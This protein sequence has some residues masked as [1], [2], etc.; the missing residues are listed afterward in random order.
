MSKKQKSI[1]IYK[2]IKKKKMKKYFYFYLKELL[3]VNKQINKIIE[4]RNAN[5]YFMKY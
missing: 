2:K 3:L 5:I 4:K 1:F